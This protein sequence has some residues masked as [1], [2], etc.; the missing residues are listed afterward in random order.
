MSET[1]Q[2]G[3]WIYKGTGVPHDAIK[4]L[5]PPPN[6]RKFT[7]EVIAG[8]RRQATIKD[9]DIRRHIG[10]NPSRNVSYDPV[11]DKELIK[12]IEMVNAALYLRRPLLVTGKPGSGKSSLAYAIAYELRLGPVLRWPITTHSTLADS[13]YHLMLP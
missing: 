3:W 2:Q 5:P 11:E 6:W 12:E 10:S 8:P 1:N 13:L 7:G 4:D 9:A